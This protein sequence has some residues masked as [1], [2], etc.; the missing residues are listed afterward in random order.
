[1]KEQKANLQKEKPETKFCLAKQMAKQTGRGGR[2]DHNPRFSASGAER[3]A[4]AGG[5]A[6]CW[7]TT[8]TAML[9]KKWFCSSMIDYLFRTR[10]HR[11]SSVYSSSMLQ[12]AA[13]YHWQWL[14]RA[15]GEDEWVSLLIKRWPICNS[16][17]GYSVSNFPMLQTAAFL[18]VTPYLKLSG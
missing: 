14:L 15:F 5:L 17:L 8:L 3:H 9:L 13:S 16:L 2:R 6:H 11:L 4:H 1:M 7:R 12:D 18:L 10:G